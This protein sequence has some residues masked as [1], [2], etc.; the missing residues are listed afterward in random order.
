MKYQS[1]SA[2]EKH[3]KEAFPGNLSLA[4]MVVCPDAVERMDLL[5]KVATLAM[6][7]GGEQ[8]TFR[9]DEKQSFESCFELLESR[10]LF[11]SHWVLILDGVEQ[12]K[13][14]EME[15]LSLYLEK[16]APF[17]YLIMGASQL[18]AQ[19]G[20]YQQAKKELILLDMSGEKPWEKKKRVKEW[21]VSEAA[22]EKKTLFEDAAL[23][24]IDS[25]GVERGVLTQELF[26]LITFVGERKSITLSDVQTMTAKAQSAGLWKLAESLVWEEEPLPRQP[27][28]DLS[29][30]IAMTSFLRN[31]LDIGLRLSSLIAKGCSPSEIAGHFPALRPQAFDRCYAVARRRQLDFFAQAQVLTFEIELD[32]KNQPPSAELLWDMLISKITYLKAKHASPPSKSSR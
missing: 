18:P 21:L 12:L 10:P 15:R 20:F 23:L 11:G 19:A 17:V 32:A 16:P 25:Q 31:Q 4:Y 29:A 2:F 22:A 30:L 28:E 9:L 6:N 3:L 13:K 1:A 14:A 8:R 27:I 7:G 26:K 5:E 24:L